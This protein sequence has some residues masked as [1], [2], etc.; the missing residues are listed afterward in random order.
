MD[1][2]N[3]DDL[4]ETASVVS[5]EK[6][7]G[8]PRPTQAENETNNQSKGRRSV[9]ERLEPSTSQKAAGVDGDGFVT[10]KQKG[11]GKT[12]ARASTSAAGTGRTHNETT[13]GTSDNQNRQRPDKN[14]RTVIITSSEGPSYGAIAKSGF[15]FNA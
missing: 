9:F 6:A 1:C 3:V 11:K 8:T 2:D 14:N 7:D 15:D 13:P 5:E 4:S 12:S 10:V